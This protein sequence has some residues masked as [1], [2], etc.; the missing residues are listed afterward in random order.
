MATGF[1]DATFVQQSGPV[2]GPRGHDA[3]IGPSEPLR[4]DRPSTEGEHSLSHFATDPFVSG[5]T[6]ARHLGIPKKNLIH[7]RPCIRMSR[8]FPLHVH[9]RADAFTHSLWA[10][11]RSAEIMNPGGVPGIAWVP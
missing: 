6:N 8:R 5:V 1:I 2:D 11:H 4:N 10:T 3:A 7:Y 9:Q